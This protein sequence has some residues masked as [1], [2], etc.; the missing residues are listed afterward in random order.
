[1]DNS[2]EWRHQVEQALRQ[3]DWRGA[4]TVCREVLGR[5]RVEAQAWVFLGEALEHQGQGPAAWRCFERA[6][7]LDPQAAWVPRAINRLKDQQVGGIPLWLDDLL[8]VPPVRVVGA[9]LARDEAENIGR[10][11]RALRPAVDSVVVVDTGSTDDTV[12]IAE[13]EGAVVVQTDWEDDFGRAR[14]AAETELGNTG[15]VLWVDADE[16][17]DHEDI[18]VPRIVA[19]LFDGVRPDVLVRI[20]QVNYIGSSV[21]PNYDT[22]RMYPLGRGWT[23]RGRIHEQVVHVDSGQ[24]PVAVRPAVRIR[25]NHWGYD[26][27]AMERRG[28][29]ERNVR[30]LEQWTADEPQN[31]AAWGFLGRDL[32]IGGHLERAVAALSR[33]E[34]VSASDTSYGRLPEVR[35]VLCEALVRLHRLDEARAVAERMTTHHPEFPTGWYWR[36]QV[37]LLQADERLK[38]AVA[39]SRQARALAPRYRGIVSVSTEVPHLLAVLT[40]AD[41]SKMQARWSDALALYKELNLKYPD[42]DGVKRQISW[43]IEESRRI[44]QSNQT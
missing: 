12:A 32:Y 11:I 14:R 36:G 7:I 16:F 3:Q 31:A 24:R 40:E 19:G 43:I 44:A 10:C 29:I 9:I 35:A 15:W 30:L 34:V 21:Q 13:S 8:S 39:W 5:N 2:M 6:W 26:A 4:E 23:W 27:P 28:K 33:A 42:H 38:D 1:M 20:G 18:A 41:A 25:L 17:L 22:T 37:A